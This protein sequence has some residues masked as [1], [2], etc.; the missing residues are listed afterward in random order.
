[1]KI[2]LFLIVFFAIFNSCSNDEKSKTTVVDKCLEV[3]CNDWENCNSGNG[4]CELKEGRCLSLSDC[5][6]KK[7]C[8]E[9]HNCVNQEIIYPEV[10]NFLA[11]PQLRSILLTW[12]NPIDYDFDKITVYYNEKSI[13]VS[14]NQQQL[15]IESLND[16][17]NYTFTIKILNNDNNYSNGITINAQTITPA[18]DYN[19]YIGPYLT[20]ITPQ[21]KDNF[22]TPT[23]LNPAENVIVN[24]ESQIPNFK[25][26]VF[27]KIKNSQNW[28]FS[29][30]DDYNEFTNPLE[31]VHHI[32]LS[33]LTPDTIY[34]YQILG[35]D[36]KLS[37]VYF[38]KTAK[39]NS[40]ETRFL[41]IGDMQDEYSKQKW[42]DVA[43]EIYTNHSNEFDFIICLGDMPKE[44]VIYNNERY[45]WWK[46]F[47]NKGK[48]LFASK[49]VFATIGNHDTPA[50][51]NAVNHPE[52]YWSNAEDSL[53]FRKYFYFSSDMNNPDYYSFNNG[54]SYFIGINSE[55]PVFYGRYPARDFN[56][57]RQQ[58]LN[59]VNF[60]T[61]NNSNSQKWFFVF[62][63][64]SPVNPSEGKEESDF[65]LPYLNYFNGKIDWLFSGHT[66]FYQR[67][68]PV[69]AFENSFN[70]NKEYGKNINQ[71]IGYLLIPPSGQWPRILNN[72]KL[73][74]EASSFPQYK[75]NSTYETGF[76]IV[77]TSD[78]T[79]KIKTYGMGDVDNRNPSQY[80][81]T[82]QCKLIDE[83]TYT[84]KEIEST[85]IFPEC[86]YRGTSNGWK[87][88]PM[89]LIDNN[90]WGTTITLSNDREN[91]EMKF[92]TNFSG[93]K[94]YGDDNPIDGKAY[95]NEQTNIKLPNEAGTYKIKFNDESRIYT[96]EKI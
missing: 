2:L 6:N 27:Y 86:F 26:K 38:F 49:V 71:G 67:T 21:L 79:I 42:R 8:N 70:L 94:W 12:K 45:Y 85:S 11:F 56:N 35:N 66:H 48:S 81:D 14:K 31:K 83:I 84:K 80:G 7:I 87:K 62:T 32:K 92:Y 18:F 64:I 44:D 55:I 17:T 15:L 34:E 58:Q 29:N 53:T 16:S 91:H 77:Q 72:S 9:N 63:H 39:N 93:E 88:T 24:Y 65:M 43:T 60:E 20:L 68:K 54:N 33:N 10:E 82:G 46:V 74:E 41:L 69:T 5:D 13:D 19:P 76:S 90:T 57:K 59:W 1:M 51:S 73:E 89:V 50:N 37:P 95:S 28:L 4:M 75:G 40:D 96:V 22:N 36:N 23:V 52:P 25:G 47:F 30:E 78:K 3:V 61:T